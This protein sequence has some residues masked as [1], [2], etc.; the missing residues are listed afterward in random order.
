M[1]FYLG[2]LYVL[3]SRKFSLVNDF[4]KLANEIWKK[5]QV[6]CSIVH[7]GFIEL[8]IGLTPLVSLSLCHIKAF[9]I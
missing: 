3:K 1:F 9:W 6:A 4:L 5:F 7:W 2:F 8:N